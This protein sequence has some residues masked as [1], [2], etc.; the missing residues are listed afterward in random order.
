[1]YVHYRVYMYV[2]IFPRLFTFFFERWCFALIPDY[3]RNDAL[4]FSEFVRGL[5]DAELLD[6]IKDD[7]EYLKLVENSSDDRLDYLLEC[8][9]W[10]ERRKILFDETVFRLS[11]S[12]DS[13]YLSETRRDGASSVC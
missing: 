13:S 12:V 1:M 6:V 8:V 7:D 3:V 9:G 11:K 5:S 2:I 10:S 4:S